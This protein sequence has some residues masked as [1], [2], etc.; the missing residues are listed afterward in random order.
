MSLRKN[1]FPLVFGLVSALS[2]ASCDGDD[3]D[4]DGTN[5][6]PPGSGTSAVFLIIDEDCIDNGNEPNNFSAPDVNDQ[7]AE[8]G[9]RQTLA[10]FQD[11]VG[12][13]IDLYT[14]S[15]GD[16]GL[17]APRTIPSTWITAGPTANGSQNYFVPGP[18]LGAPDPDDNREIRLDDIPGVTPL[19]ANGLSMLTGKTVYAVVYDGDISINYSPLRGNLQGANLGIVAFEILSVEARTNGSDGDLPR[20]TV[21]VKST[22]DVAALQL[23]L[24]ANAPVPQSS[25]EPFDVT[26]PANPGVPNLTDAP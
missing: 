25:S 21:R 22:G 13:T 26:A 2:L 1:V 10:F 15:V 17:F 19:R 12:Q 6:P 11:N 24:F 7:L 20:I 8:I 3:N 5:N 14:G 16:E 18:G 23:S 4:D 9:L